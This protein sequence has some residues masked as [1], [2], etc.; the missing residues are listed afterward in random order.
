MRDMQKQNNEKIAKLKDQ[1]A[2]QQGKEGN[3]PKP[4]EKQSGGKSGQGNQTGNNQ[5]SEQ[6]ARLAAQ[7][8]ALRREMQKASEQ[9]NKDGKNGNGSMQKLA[10]KMEKTETE[11]VNKMITEETLRRQQEILTRLLDAEKAERKQDMD[12]KRESKEGK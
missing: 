6:L 12:Q 10:E 8:E 4:G 5:F 2:K 1:M 7:Q 9:F 11:L 3:K